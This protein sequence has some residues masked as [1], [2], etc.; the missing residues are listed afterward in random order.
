MAY[1]IIVRGGQIADG[2]GAE[3]RPADVA[4][5]ADT[6]AAVGDLAS[7]DAADIVD[8]AGRL[9]FPGFIDVHCHADAL[10]AQPRVQQAMLTQGV[11]SVI[12]GQDGL[13]FPLADGPSMAYVSRYFAAVN[14]TASWLPPG[15]LPVGEFLDGVTR[16]SA[17]NAGTLIPAGTLRARVVGLADRPAT[18]EEITR[19]R[20]LT[21]EG[22][23]D[24]ALGLST[25]L[26][27]VP[28]IFASAAEI[29]AVA[30]PVGE[31][32]GV[33]ASHLRGYASD[34][35]AASVGELARIAADAGAAG[36]ISHLHGQA[37]RVGAALAA[38]AADYGQP[39]SYDSYPYLRGSTLLAMIV[40]PRSVQAAGVDATVGRLAEPE[41]RTR[42]RERWLPGDPRTGSIT[43]TYAAADDWRWAEGMTLTAAAAQAGTDLADFVCDLLTGCDLAVGCTV[44]NYTDRTESDLR[45][46]LRGDGHMASSDGIYLGS[47]PHPRGWGAFAAALGRHV[48]ELGDWTW[49]QAAWHLSGHAA[50]RFGLGRRGI[51]T[52]GAIADL[53]VI[54]PA[55]V[56]AQSGYSSPMLTA[57]GVTDVLV[58]GVP[59]VTAGTL[60]GA[61]PGRV[62]RRET[63]GELKS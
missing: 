28:G 7:A 63:K 62:L 9:V 34:R 23:R 44:A 24:G 54:D 60:T 30:G 59:V 49:G 6:I 37:A 3:P 32:G 27:Y 55:A 18:G 58:A 31:H 22:M 14:G 20:A 16:G 25:G 5:G 41:V 36:H 38:A 35:I 43:L 51:I 11:T 57:A 15:G 2:T 29:A 56:G 53:A 8:A 4:I 61:T 46:L 40:L 13:S 17:V 42:L 39:L 1:D 47:A 21:D 26:D 48:R 52:P 12:L 33:I 45:E 19:M 10:L 50:R